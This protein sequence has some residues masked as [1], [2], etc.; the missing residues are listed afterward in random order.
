MISPKRRCLTVKLH[1]AVSQKTISFRE[2]QYIPSHL[3][4]STQC[5]TFRIS[6]KILCIF[7]FSPTFT[8]CSFYSGLCDIS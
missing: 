1:G 8:T 3:I 4:F 5:L 2:I 7:L 6:T